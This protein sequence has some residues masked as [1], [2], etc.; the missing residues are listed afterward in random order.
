L[1]DTLQSYMTELSDKYIHWEPNYEVALQRVR[2]EKK[3][4]FVYF[5][6]P[7]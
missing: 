3:E 1:F 5:T 4:L 7:N 6:K 2:A